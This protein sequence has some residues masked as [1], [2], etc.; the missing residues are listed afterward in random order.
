MA[1]HGYR[2]IYDIKNITI[3]PEMLKLVADIDE[4]KGTGK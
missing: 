3:T 2:P 4:F 1:I